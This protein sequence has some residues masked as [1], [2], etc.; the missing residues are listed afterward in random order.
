MSF[1]LDVCDAL[2]KELLV[3]GFVGGGTRLGVLGG[4]SLLS[5]AYGVDWS[6][7][8]ISGF[9][10]FSDTPSRD[11]GKGVR[12]TSKEGWCFGICDLGLVR[13]R[14]IPGFPEVSRYVWVLET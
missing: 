8:V 9:S 13:A 6:V 4:V 7:S 12:G 2:R 1:V 3:S 5:R 11:C 14:G 10:E